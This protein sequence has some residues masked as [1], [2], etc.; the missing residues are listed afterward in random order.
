M[1]T[2]G[3]VSLDLE[4]ALVWLEYALAR[5]LDS[6]ATEAVEKALRCVLRAQERG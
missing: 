1:R 2:D 4:R 6:E 5:P 3:R